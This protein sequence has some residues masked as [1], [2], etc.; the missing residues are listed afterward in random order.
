MEELK[1]CPFCGGEARVSGDYR[2]GF[3]ITCLGETCGCRFGIEYDNS[4][5]PNNDYV[6]EN[7]AIK[8]WNKRI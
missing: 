6:T 5:M 1:P 4:A 2:Y 3:G 7:E 8:K